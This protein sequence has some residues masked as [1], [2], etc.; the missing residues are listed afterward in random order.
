[1]L[2]SGR[3]PRRCAGTDAPPAAPIMANHKAGVGAA[4]SAGGIVMKM[5]AGVSLAA[6]ALLIGTRPSAQAP[7]PSP[8][9]QKH[10]AAARAAAGTDHLGVFQPVC[11]GAVGLGNPPA[12]RGG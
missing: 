1:M 6:G 12:A 7:A 11:D 2:P 3:A 8:D 5:L 10:I 9:A 4:V